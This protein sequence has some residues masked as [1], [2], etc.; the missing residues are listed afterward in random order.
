MSQYATR[1]EDLYWYPK[2]APPVVPP[3]VPP[4]PVVEQPLVVIPPSVPLPATPV[5]PSLKPSKLNALKAGYVEAQKWC[6]AVDPTVAFLFGLLLLFCIFIIHLNNRVK[7]LETM[8]NF[9]LYQQKK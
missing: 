4:N 6:F 7:N 2:N 5:L 3:M 1:I 9:L 8:V